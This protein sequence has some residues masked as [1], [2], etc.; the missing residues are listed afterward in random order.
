M[1]KKK[2][3]TK[4]TKELSVAISETSMADQEDTQVI[5]QKKRGRPRKVEQEISAEEQ[6]DETDELKKPKTSDQEDDG[7]EDQLKSAKIE[8]ERK[9]QQ[10]RSSRARRKGK[11]M[12]S[13]T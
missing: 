9:L 10:P 5:T 4:K 2:V 13:S 11:P 12:K 1:G 3:L 7:E 8:Q 6:E